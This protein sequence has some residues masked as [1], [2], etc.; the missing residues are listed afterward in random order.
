NMTRAGA[1]RIDHAFALKRLFWV[2][3]GRTAEA[4]T[5]VAYPFHEL[6][7]VLKL[8]SQRNRCLVI[9]EDLGTAPEGFGAA[10]AEAGVLSYRLLYFEREPDGGFK[11]PDHYPS[12][13]LAAAST[14]DL[15]TVA[16][17]WRGGDIALRSALELYPSAEPRERD[18]AQR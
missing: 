11:A 7:A 16:G 12:L 14:H 18:R 15:P 13:A 8:E 1:L 2:P 17:W 6:L 10:C 5:Y 9:G 4:G 3:D